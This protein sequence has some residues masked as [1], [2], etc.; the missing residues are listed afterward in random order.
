VNSFRDDDRPLPFI[1][2]SGVSKTFGGVNALTDISFDIRVGVV[3]GLVGANG[4]GKSTLIRCLAG[5]HQPDSGTIEIDGEPVVIAE[6]DD[7]SAHGLSFIHQEM[8]LI[9]RWDVL[10]NMALG[11]PPKTHGKLIDWR[12]TRARAA[13]VAQ[14]LGMTFKLS[15]C[16]DDLSV[17]EKWLVLIGRA[18]MRDARLIAMDEPTASLSATEVERLQAVIRMLVARGTAVLFVSHRLDEVSELCSDVTVF[19]DGFVTERVVDRPISKAQLVHA[20]VGRELVIPEHGHEPKTPGRPILEVRHLSDDTIVKDV[21]LVVHEGEVVGLGG[22]V[23]AGR[24]EVAK[25]VFGAARAIAGEVLLDGRPVAFRHPSD[26]V[27]AGIGF[28]PEERRAEG[29]FLDRTIDF[30][31]NIAKLGS[32]ITSRWWPLLKVREGHRRAQLVADL[33]TVKAKDVGTL[34]G[35][36]SG[37]NQQKVVIARWL[38]DRPQLLILDEPSRGVDVGARADLYDVIRKLTETG[39]AVLVISSDNEELVTLCDRVVVMAEGRVTGTLT[40]PAITV[41][42]IVHR[43]FA[44]EGQEVSAP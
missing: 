38:L 22:L 24:S 30:N 10:R 32:M 16:V 15:T 1:R 37:G 20:I 36:L 6:P 13:E 11:L 9:P 3:H 14:M 43:S 19:K 40:G 27:A 31:I 23:G 26:A 7:A 44:H 5:I 29:V 39:T 8:S 41:E 42:H 17:A 35:N 2:I 4:A 28:V 12:P 18:L 25:I 34:V 21:S 33:V